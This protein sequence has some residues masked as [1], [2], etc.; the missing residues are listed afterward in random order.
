MKFLNEYKDFEPAADLVEKYRKEIEEKYKVID[1]K[2]SGYKLVLIDDRI[3]YL[4]G[5]YGYKS[6]VVNRIFFDMS[7]DSS[8]HEPSLRRAIK[9]WVDYNSIQ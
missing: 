4:N 5:P 3:Y 8:L 7:Y 2:T 9:D 1:D 6:K